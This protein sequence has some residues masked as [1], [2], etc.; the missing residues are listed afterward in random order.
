[1]CFIAAAGGLF[2]CD[3]SAP[4]DKYASPRVVTFS[5]ALTSMMLALG[6]EDHLVGVDRYSDLPENIQ[7]PIVGDTLNVRAEPILAVR[8]DIILSQVDVAG[9]EPV[10]RIDPHI[11][12]EYIRIESLTDI[13]AAVERVGELVGKPDLARQK[14]LDFEAALE[15]VHEKCAGLPSPR[16]LFVLGYREPSSVGGGTFVGQLIENAGGV[17]IMAEEFALWKQPALERILALKPDVVICQV[18]AAQ[19]RDAEAYWRELLGEKVSVCVVTDN[20]WTIPGLHLAAFADD[21]ARM[22]HGTT[23]E[24]PPVTDDGKP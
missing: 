13:S 4:Q 16:V 1:M 5:P 17:N 12:A 15:R 14:R 3:R 22:I 18:N 9:F 7:R 2:G 6:L 10:L 8:P 23:Y 24:R 19:A 20:R 11:R 21:L